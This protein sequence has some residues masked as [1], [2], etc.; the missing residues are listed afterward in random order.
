MKIAVIDNYDSFVYNLIRYL[1][2][3]D[4]RQKRRRDLV[5]M[6]RQLDLVVGFKLHMGMAPG[7]GIYLA[8]QL[9]PEQGG[10]AG[11]RRERKIADF[12][13]RRLAAGYGSTNDLR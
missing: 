1:K 8:G 3:E 10:A 6:D 11:T 7:A 13:P 5:V 4:L 2:E 9:R 12:A